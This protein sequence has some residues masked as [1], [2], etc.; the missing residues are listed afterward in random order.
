MARVRL[1]LKRDQ[2]V[3]NFVSTMDMDLDMSVHLLNAD[4]DTDLYGWDDV[5]HAKVVAGIYAAYE[6][7]WRKEA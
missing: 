7:K 2:I 1:N 4:V 3:D 5:T 6:I